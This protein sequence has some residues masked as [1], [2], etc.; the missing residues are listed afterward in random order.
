MGPSWFESETRP[1]DP[2]P[3]RHLPHVAACAVL[4]CLPLLTVGCTNHQNIHSDRHTLPLESSYQYADLAMIF[5]EQVGDFR[6]VAIFQ[7]NR[8]EVGAEYSLSLPSKL[9]SA[10]VYLYA[11]AAIPTAGA[12]L[13]TLPPGST[14]LIQK[15]FEKHKRA[16]MES[17]P[18][19]QLIFESQLTTTVWN[20]PRNGKMACFAYQEPST[21]KSWRT[22]LFV[23]PAFSDQWA[24]RYVFTYSAEPTTYSTLTACQRPEI[25]T[26]QKRIP[27]NTSAAFAP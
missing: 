19:I 18:G 21:L 17:H 20:D 27:L 4:G 22:T 8:P 6:R 3:P 1:P 9:M 5:P 26:F 10:H 11:A 23:Y 12:P 24:L 16:L 15:D 7:D 14:P 13:E 2:H 25:A